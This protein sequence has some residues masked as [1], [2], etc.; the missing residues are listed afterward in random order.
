[1]MRSLVLLG[2]VLLSGCAADGTPEPQVVYVTQT[3]TETATPVQ[4]P[5][6]DGKV[7]SAFAMQ[8]G[9]ADDRLYVTALESGDDWMEIGLMTTTSRGGM[10]WAI[11]ENVNT[12]GNTV[13][14]TKAGAVWYESLPVKEGDYIDLC[15]ESGATNAVVVVSELASGEELGRFTFSTLA[16]CPKP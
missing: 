7:S 5:P 2:V 11:N 16:N 8:I 14:S 9:D 15:Q 6:P 1:M 13:P 3:V 12:Y 10:H 4:A